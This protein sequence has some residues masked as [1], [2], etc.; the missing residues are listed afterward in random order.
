MAVKMTPYQQY[1]HKSRYA[2]WREEDQ[3]R[4]TWEETV[5]RLV[6]YYKKQV[7]SK[8]P[9]SEMYVFDELRE[10]IL[11]LKVMPS[12]RA[13]MTAGETLDRCHVPAYNCAYVTVDSP[14]TFDETMYVL[15]CG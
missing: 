12:M 11:D 2:R 10:Y 4:E 13:L 7:G 15:M 9:E 8:V 14:R 1:I 5:D 3:R 6:A